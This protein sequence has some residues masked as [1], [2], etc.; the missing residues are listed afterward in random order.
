MSIPLAR[1]N[2]TSPTKSTHKP[3]LL[4]VDPGESGRE[5]VLVDLQAVDPTELKRVMNSGLPAF[6]AFQRVS[7]LATKP[8]AAPQQKQATQMTQPAPAQPQPIPVQPQAFN[9]GVPLGQMQV[10]V[11]LPVMPLSPAP[12][13]Y[14]AEIARLQ[15]EQQ[16]EQA[17]LRSSTAAQP[18]LLDTI[19]RAVGAQFEA[20][21]QDMESRLLP[22]ASS[23]P[24]SVPAVLAKPALQQVQEHLN[25]PVSAFDSLGM[26]F[27]LGPEPS[28]PQVRVR[29][30]L[31]YGGFID[32]RYHAVI[33][34]EKSMI[35]VYDTRFTYG[36][37]FLP[38]ET[39]L[40]DVDPD[41]EPAQK[42]E[43]LIKAN[44]D[45]VPVDYYLANFGTRFE[46]G[47]LAFCVL[48]IDEAV[49]Q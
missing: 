32:A 28:P 18:E 47:C 23:Q 8:A 31:P 6:Q 4:H 39:S 26:P 48:L 25:A 38:P 49:E 37:Q 45:D 19:M 33:P 5:G 14:Q 17:R 3:G 9:P 22:A 40:E 30:K 13:D 27:K 44:V 16:A 36:N 20:F 24:A 35:L 11:G 46:L 12:R 7:Q 1:D 41:A 15:A 10:P 29:F 21:R 42:R 2:D 34:T 43:T